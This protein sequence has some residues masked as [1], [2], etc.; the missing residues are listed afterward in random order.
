MPLDRKKYLYTGQLCSNQFERNSIERR[1][2]QDSS[3]FSGVISLFDTVAE[4][5][6]KTANC[7]NINA[8]TVEN[9]SFEDDI[10]NLRR[11]QLHNFSI[12]KLQIV[13]DFQLLK[14]ALIVRKFYNVF[15][16]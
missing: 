2:Q 8:I 4:S 7:L 11:R 16:R 14:K 15:G 9:R 3:K 5:H 1:S 13:E 10:V 12:N 6:P